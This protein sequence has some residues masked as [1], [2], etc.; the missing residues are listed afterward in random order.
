MS[1]QGNWKIDQQITVNLVDEIIKFTILD[2]L[3]SGTFG[4]VWLIGNKDITLIVKKPK[5]EKSVKLEE[6]YMLREARFLLSLDF[7]PNV[8]SCFMVD[9]ISGIPC[10]LMDYANKGS[11]RNHLRGRLLIS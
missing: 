2:D 8:V 3:G 9:S 10:L 6:T 7:H 11:L 4:E 5:I 1:S